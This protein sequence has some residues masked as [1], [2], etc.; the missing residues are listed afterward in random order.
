MPCPR[1][2]ALPNQ[3][4]RTPPR[5]VCAN[6]DFFRL[7]ASVRIALELIVVFPASARPT[8]LTAILS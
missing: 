6:L 4:N 1:G 2:E 3:P 7:A 5:D 8:T